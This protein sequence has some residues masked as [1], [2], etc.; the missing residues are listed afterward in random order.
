MAAF[1]TIRASRSRVNQTNG[2]PPH[3][4]ISSLALYVQVNYETLGRM[5][6]YPVRTAAGNFVR[7]ARDPGSQADLSFQMRKRAP[8]FDTRAIPY[9]TAIV[10]VFDDVPPL[11][12]LN[13]TADPGVIVAGTSA[14]I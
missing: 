8:N 2:L 1:L 6:S 5:G 12:R 11:L 3:F 9:C 14:L 4:R 7:V 13:E 10:T